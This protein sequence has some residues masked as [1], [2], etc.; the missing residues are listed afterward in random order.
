MIPF[1]GKFVQYFTSE[2]NEWIPALVTQ[3]NNDGSV[4]L[5]TFPSGNVKF[6]YSVNLPNWKPDDSST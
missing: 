2:D 5:T 1:V 4:N 3:V 6:A